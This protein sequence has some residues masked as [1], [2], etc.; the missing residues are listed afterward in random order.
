MGTF[1]NIVF[2][3]GPQLVWANIL[4]ICASTL[5]ALFLLLLA[6]GWG[7]HFSRLIR[8]SALLTLSASIAATIAAQHFY[9]THTSWVAFLDAWFRESHA[10]QSFAPVYTELVNANQQ[11]AVLGW[12][13]VLLTGILLALS[14]LSL[15]PLV[16][17]G[18]QRHLPAS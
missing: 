5:L 16:M 17:L 8:L 2:D 7:R 11:A 14:L 12:I 10:P 15:G 4:V 3:P 9:A 6:V 1:D 18:R 13:G